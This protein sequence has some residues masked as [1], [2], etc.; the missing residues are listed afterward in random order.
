MLHLAENKYGFVYKYAIT[1]LFFDLHYLGV[2]VRV[3]KF[4]IFYE[5]K[6]IITTCVFEQN[7]IIF[8]TGR[9]F[10]MTKAIVVKF[11]MQLVF[12]INNIRAMF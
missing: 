9:K 1:C 11:A 8:L 3:I 10:Q 12:G 6:K 2:I 5:L 7:Q 4:F